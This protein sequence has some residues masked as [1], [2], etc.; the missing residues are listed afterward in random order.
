MTFTRSLTR[1]T[2]EAMRPVAMRPTKGS[3]SIMVTSI[4]RKQLVNMM[5]STHVDKHVAAIL[6]QS[7]LLRLLTH[8]M[9]RRSGLCAKYPLRSH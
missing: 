8:V 7:Q 5:K 4:C 9:T 6:T 3:S 2:P 1:T